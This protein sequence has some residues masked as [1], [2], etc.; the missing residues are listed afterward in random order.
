[1]G[2]TTPFNH[3]GNKNAIMQAL[4]GRLIERMADGFRSKTPPGGV[5]DRVWA[6]GGIAVDLLLEQPEL[7]KIV[8]GSLGVV[9]PVPSAVMKHFRS[10]WSLAL[11]NLDGLACD[12]PPMAQAVLADQL[13]FAFRGC[14]SFWIAG[15][16]GDGEL[17]VAV[18]ASASA[19][20]L[21]VVAPD[22]RP[23]V[24]APLFRR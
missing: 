21:G 6:M 18:Q 1:M 2:F 9:S 7:Y 24:L 4:S 12:V 15:E 22:H 16:I 17:H 8:V 11:G 14:L 20:L 10:L 3:F 19:I 23:R 13:A 5:I